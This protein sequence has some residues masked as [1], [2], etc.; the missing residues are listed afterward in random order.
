MAVVSYKCNEVTIRYDEG[1]RF[2]LYTD[3]LIEEL[4][5]N[6]EEYGLERLKRKLVE[7]NNMLPEELSDYIIDDVMKWKAKKD[8]EDD[9]TFIVFSF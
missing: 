7:K 8:L 5:S 9:M 2:Y 4:N 6:G 3:G 1:D